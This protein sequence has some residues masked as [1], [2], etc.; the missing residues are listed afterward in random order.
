MIRG[1]SIGPSEEETEDIGKEGRE[2]WWREGEEEAGQRRSQ[3]IRIFVVKQG[4]SRLL[5]PLLG[6]K[7]DIN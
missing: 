6:C 2:G 3:S 1:V 7:A 5:C 4:I